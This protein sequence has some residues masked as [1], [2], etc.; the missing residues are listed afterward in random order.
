MKQMKYIW[1]QVVKK[2]EMAIWIFLDRKSNFRYLNGYWKSSWIAQVP[3]SIIENRNPSMLPLTNGLFQLLDDKSCY[4]I[5]KKTTTTLMKK[6]MSS[7]NLWNAFTAFFV[8][9][10]ARNNCYTL[11]TVLYPIHSIE[12]EIS[13][14]SNLW[15]FNSIV[16]G[17]LSFEQNYCDL[18]WN[19]SF[20]YCFILS[21]TWVCIGLNAVF[22]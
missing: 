8:S 14:I 15:R 20:Q 9:L 16:I 18:F 21:T 19:S 4:D 5:L 2:E 22:S 12:N 13:F 1:V 3:T 10:N 11:S 17:E 6:V 7:K